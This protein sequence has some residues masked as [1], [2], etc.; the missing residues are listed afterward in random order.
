MWVLWHF[1]S[2]SW[3]KLSSASS[4]IQ[5]VNIENLFYFQRQCFSKNFEI[6]AIIE[7]SCGYILKHCLLT[8]VTMLRFTHNLDNQQNRLS[9]LRLKHSKTHFVKIEQNPSTWGN[10]HILMNILH[11]RARKWCNWIH[12]SK[13]GVPQITLFLNRDLP[14]KTL[15][16]GVPGTSFVRESMRRRRDVTLSQCDHG[17]KEKRTIILPM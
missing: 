16:C 10:C 5:N 17:I 15:K 11:L 7:A 2:K 1:P 9:K 8:E 3:S 4:T 13:V 14:A 6:K 12:V